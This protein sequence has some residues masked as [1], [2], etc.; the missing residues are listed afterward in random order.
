VAASFFRLYPPTPESIRWL[1]SIPHNRNCEG[2][3]R[4]E[5]RDGLVEGILRGT[6]E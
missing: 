4:G 6:R 5:T 1:A 3:C 2:V